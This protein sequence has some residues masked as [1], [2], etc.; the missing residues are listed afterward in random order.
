MTTD[1]TQA[2]ETARTY[3]NSD[4]AD[5][6]YFH[7]WGGEDI[8]VGLYAAAD[9][10]IRDASRRTVE[11]MAEQFDHLDATTRLIDVGGGYGGS[12]RHLARTHGVPSVVLNISEKENERDRAMNE[13]AGL[14][15]LIEVIDGD[16][17]D[18]PAD[19]A[20]FD[21]AWSQDAILHSDNRPKVLQE[22][23][24]V[25]KPGASFLLTD[26][27][28]TD[29]APRDKLKPIYE[30]LHLQSLASPGFYEQAA[31]EVGL[32]LVAFEE[33]ADMLAMHYSR[34]LEELTRREAELREENIVSDAYIER[35]KKGLRHWIDGGHQGHLTWG[36]F[37]FQKA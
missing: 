10:P 22:V 14:S 27:M 24:R 4:D 37:L 15:H 21:G 9:E 7:I 33:H 6:F 13:E 26:P 11:R 34:V 35:M 31:S 23:A 17:A 28:Q 1:Y 3:Y 2:V 36:V 16:F 19:D 29:E 8:H 18:I 5:N 25:L 12:M 20:S 30:R 32:S